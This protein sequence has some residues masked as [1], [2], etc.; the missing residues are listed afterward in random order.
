M[1]RSWLNTL[2][3]APVLLDL[4]LCS[5]FALA[6]ILTSC[7]RTPSPFA[8]RAGANAPRGNRD[9]IV[10]AEMDVFAGQSAREV[11][12]RLHPNWLHARGVSR[13]IGVVV[14][15]TSRHDLQELNF[16]NS[17]DIE[18]MRHLSAA[19]AFTKY[20]TGYWGGVIEVTSRSR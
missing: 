13:G 12:E 19:D 3:A 6:L 10:R 18:S 15:G 17:A 2:S 9:L 16:L 5:L 20:G 8:E 11:V 7:S 1:R 14:D 4:R